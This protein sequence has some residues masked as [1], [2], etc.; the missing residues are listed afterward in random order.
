MAH[1]GRIGST[2]RNDWWFWVQASAAILARPENYRL[3][4]SVMMVT[5][6]CASYTSVSPTKESYSS[7]VMVFTFLS[8]LGFDT[9][10]W[11]EILTCLG[12]ALSF[13]NGEAYAQECAILP[14][15]VGIWLQNAE[16]VTPTS[17]LHIFFWK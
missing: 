7:L 10:L 17:Y 12:R 14:S 15:Q 11:Y 8:K 1:L 3:H 9:L 6:P 2:I 13:A 4:K 5:L 16:L